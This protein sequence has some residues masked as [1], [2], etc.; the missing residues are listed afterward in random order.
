MPNLFLKDEFQKI[1]INLLK[2][3]VES[4]FFHSP[5]AGIKELK[6]ELKKLM[7]NREGRVSTK[8]IMVTSGSQQGLDL[9]VRTFVNP[10]DVILVDEPTFFGAIQLFQALGAKVV[11]VPIDENGIRVDVLEYLIN[12]FKPKFIYS[13]LNFENHFILKMEEK[14]TLL[15]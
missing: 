6:K 12:K 15:D 8:N 11:G 13:V 5:V 4:M 7:L 3:K 10:N 1:Q 9:I 14:V 2:N